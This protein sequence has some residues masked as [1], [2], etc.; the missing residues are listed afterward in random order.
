MQVCLFCHYSSESCGSDLIWHMSYF[1]W[2]DENRAGQ[3]YSWRKSRVSKVNRRTVTRHWQHCT[4]TYF[5][6]FCRK[7]DFL[8]RV[9]A[10]F[11]YLYR[12]TTD[13]WHHK[14]LLSILRPWRESNSQLTFF[15]NLIERWFRWVN[16]MHNSLIR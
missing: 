4:R 10:L 11:L 2:I 8:V 3:Y 14:V 15:D 5:K 12:R 6:L 9:V 16:N 13:T 7:A 1:Y